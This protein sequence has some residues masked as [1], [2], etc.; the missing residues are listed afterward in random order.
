MKDKQEEF[1]GLAQSWRFGISGI[2]ETCSSESCDWSASLDGYRLFREYKQGGRGEGVALYVTEGV[3][4]V[5]LTVGNSSVES[6][7]I[8]LKGQTKGR[9]QVNCSCPYGGFQLARNY[10]GEPTAATTQ[11]IHKKTWMTILWNRC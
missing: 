3:E 6:F 5:E 2:T 7:W 10:L 1:K 8:R 11:K 4:F 9:F